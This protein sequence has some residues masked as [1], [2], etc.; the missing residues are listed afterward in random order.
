MKLIRI[1]LVVNNK[2]IAC[3]GIILNE[4]EIIIDA[5]PI[6]KWM[7]GKKLLEIKQF[8]SKTKYLGTHIKDI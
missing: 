8:Y 2:F 3:F 7:I 5:A 6:G 4:Q 1:E